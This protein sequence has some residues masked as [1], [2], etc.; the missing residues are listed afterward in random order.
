[1]SANCEF[2]RALVKALGL[3]PNVRAFELRIKINELVLVKAEIIP[4]PP[5]VDELGQLVAV[6]KEYELHEREPGEG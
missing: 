2:V 3:P 5:S 1:M 4:Q 6:L